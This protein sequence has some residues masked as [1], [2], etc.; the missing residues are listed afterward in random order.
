MH[1]SAESL[2]ATSLLELDHVSVGRPITRAGVSL[3]PVYL[4]R[5]PVEALVE[6]PRTIRTGPH[7]PVTIGEQSVAEVPTLLA[8]NHGDEL[9]L[10]VSGQIV[11]GGLQTRVL[12]V[13]VLLGAHEQRPIP[14]SCVEQGRWSGGSAFHAGTTF[15]PRRV[16]RAKDATVAENLRAGGSKRSDQGVVWNAVSLELDRM[17]IDDCSSRLSAAAVRLGD[18]RRIAEAADELRQRGPLPGQCGVVV[19]HGSR[20]VSTE[21]FA[22]PEMLAA[23][24]DALVNGILLDAPDHEPTGKP[25][26]TRAVKLLHRFANGAATVSNGVGL[27]VERH[28]RTSRLVGQALVLDDLI[29]HASAFAL[30]A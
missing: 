10:L 30:A 21:L 27:G 22:H 7:A 26:L 16:R 15:A 20:V 14:V 18:D 6:W 29:V 8:T 1:T 2:D 3:I 17:D 23:H 4:H 11:E 13:S 25:S 12:N 19:A 28:V 9:A 5:P 24:W